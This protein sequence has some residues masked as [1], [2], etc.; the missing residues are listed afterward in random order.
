M[1]GCNYIRPLP[2]RHRFTGTQADVSMRA[3]ATGKVINGA[4]HKPTAPFLVWLKARGGANAGTLQLRNITTAQNVGDPI[5]FDS[6]GRA[7]IEL[8][9]GPGSPG[10]ANF[11]TRGEELGISYTSGGA[12]DDVSV[13]ALVAEVVP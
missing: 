5:E 4:T 13:E 7:C 8:P 10:F 11:P 3:T 1:F 12:D 9:V 2:F 6:S